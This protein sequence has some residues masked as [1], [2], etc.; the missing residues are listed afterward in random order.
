VRRRSTEK[1][2]DRVA[3]ELLDRAAVSL[4]LMAEPGV[5]G[6]E[7]RANVLRIELLGARG[8]ANEVGEEDGDD[9]AFFARGRRRGVELRTAGAENLNP[10]GFSWPQA[11]QICMR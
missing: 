3:D 4:Q 2:D 8:E 6:G 9:L 5:V 11:G 7:Q 10:A 1:G